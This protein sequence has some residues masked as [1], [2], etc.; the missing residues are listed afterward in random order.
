MA[1]QPEPS[2]AV[3]DVDDEEEEEDMPLICDLCGKMP[4]VEVRPTA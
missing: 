2:V 4:D 3:D 1:G